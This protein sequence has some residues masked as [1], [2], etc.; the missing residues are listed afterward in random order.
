MYLNAGIN[1]HEKVAALN[2]VHYIPSKLSVIFSKT[3]SAIFKKSIYIIYFVHRRSTVLNTSNITIQY[4]NTIKQ[5]H[6]KSFGT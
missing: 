5:N 2:V 1:I 3:T 6:V 4:N